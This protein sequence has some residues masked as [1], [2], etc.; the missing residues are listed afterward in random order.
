MCANS[1]KLTTILNSDRNVIPIRFHV[2]TDVKTIAPEDIVPQNYFTARQIRQADE[3]FS[4]EKCL[5]EEGTP[6]R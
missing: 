4:I 3:H 1:M 2:S 6:D 5:F